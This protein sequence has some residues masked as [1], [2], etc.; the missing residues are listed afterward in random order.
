MSFIR[1]LIRLICGDTNASTPGTGG[2]GEPPSSPPA[3][4]QPKTPII[5]QIKAIAAEG[6]DPR[7]VIGKQ[8]LFVR[9]Q[10]RDNADA[11]FAELRDHQPILNIGPFWLVSRF[12]DVEEILHR[13]TV[14]GVPYL[15]NMNGPMTPVMFGR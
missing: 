15:P 10:I 2:G 3:P 4:P 7:A 13:E 11:F 6:D 5:D 8:M 1:G 9:S 12:R 14:F